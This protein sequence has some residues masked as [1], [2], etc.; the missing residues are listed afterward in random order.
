MP[1]VDGESLYD[2]LNRERRL[3]LDDA[4]RIA[5]EAARALDVRAPAGRGP[6]R[7]E[8]RE[9]PAHPRRHDPGRRLRHRPRARRATTA[10]TAHR[11]PGRLALLHE[12]GADERR[13]GGRAH[14]PLLAG[15]GAVRD[16]GRRAAVRGADAARRSWR[17]GSPSRRRASGPLRDT[18][19]PP[20]TRPSGRRWRRRRPTGSPRWRSSPQALHGAGAE[21]ACD[22]AAR[23][24]HLASPPPA[25]RPVAAAGGRGAL[26]SSAAVLLLGV[27]ALRLA[28][29]PIGRPRARQ[30]A[31]VVAVLPSTTWAT[32]PTPTSPTASPTR[33]APSWPRSPGSR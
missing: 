28:A 10:L 5:T 12:P 19:P 3:P 16:A 26:S 21:H 15:G 32:R 2:R 14:R 8:A 24:R 23:R 11:H 25:V 30:R 4:L 29:G 7:R 18:V 6:P 22:A 13:G 1:F 31:R 17:S 33:S 9:H 20:W 27:G